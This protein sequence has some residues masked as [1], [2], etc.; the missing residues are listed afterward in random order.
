MSMASS[1]PYLV[2]DASA[3]LA[4]VFDEPDSEAV[5]EHPAIPS[6][7]VSALNCSEAGAKLTKRGLPEAGLPSELATL[8]LDISHFD[9]TQTHLTAGLRPETHKLRSSLDDRCY[10]ALARL[11][12]T[13]VLTVD[14]GWQQQYL[15]LMWFG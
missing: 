13:R 5:L 12:D 6:D 1:S 14:K 3:L 9:E 7:E 8:G 15:G 2:Y 11:H 10:L 4:A